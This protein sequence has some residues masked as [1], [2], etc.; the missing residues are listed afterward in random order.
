METREPRSSSELQEKKK[1][2][3]CGKPLVNDVYGDRCED[4]YTLATVSKEE[5]E[6]RIKDR[7]TDAGYRA[8]KNFADTEMKK[9]LKNAGE[10]NPKKKKHSEG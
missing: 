7:I 8:N 1:C 6:E 3:V 2:R 9:D 4:C 10:R 5:Q